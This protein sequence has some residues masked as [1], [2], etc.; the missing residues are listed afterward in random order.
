MKR[1]RAYT[2]FELMAVCAILA[3]LAAMVAIPQYAKYTRVREV[4]DAAAV[5]AQDIAYL[6]RF[7]QNSGPFEGATLDVKSD[8]PLRYM[9]YSG[10]PALLDPQSHIRGVLIVRQFENVSLVPGAL[11]R[12]SPLLFA[13]NGSVQYVSGNLWADQHVPV[14]I[15]LRSLGDKARTATIGLNP[16]TGAVSNVDG[17][18]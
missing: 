14:T 11:D 7:A 10:R 2:I 3:A 13:H 4:D 12:H 1:A 17:G 16:F 8:D 5:L 9:C 15:E 6:E 18:L